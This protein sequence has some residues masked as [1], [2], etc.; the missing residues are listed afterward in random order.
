MKQPARETLDRYFD[1]ELSAEELEQFAVWLAESP[2]HAAEFASQARFEFLVKEAW[3][4]RQACAVDGAIIAVGG[5]D[6][7]LAGDLASTAA[8]RQQA[9][10][11]FSAFRVTIVMAVALL[12][13]AVAGPQIWSSWSRTPQATSHHAEFVSSAGEG[14][15]SLLPNAGETFATGPD[16]MGPE[17]LGGSDEVARVTGLKGV[18]WLAGHQRALGQRL[19]AGILRFQRGTVRIVFTGGVVASVVG[20][21]ELHLLAGDH[22]RLIAGTFAAY[23]P[24][25]AEGF[26]LD[27]PGAEITDLGTEFGASVDLDGNTDLSVF[28]GSVQ[29]VAKGDGNREIFTQGQGATISAAGVMRPQFLLA[30]F[31]EPRD[32]ISGYKIVWEPFGPGSATGPF[33]G[34][35]DAGWLG[36]WQIEASPA[37]EQATVATVTDSQPLHPGTERYLELLSA[38]G[39]GQQMVRLDARRPYGSVDSFSIEEPYTIECLVR[40]QSNPSVL[41][42]FEIAGFMGA[43]AEEN[44]KPCWQIVAGRDS[45]AGSIRWQRPPK[46]SGEEA[47]PGRALDTLMVGWWESWRI[48]VAVDPPQNRWRFMLASPTQSWASE[49]QTLSMTAGKSIGCHEIAFT[50]SG[51]TSHR[52][53]FAID[54]VKIRNRP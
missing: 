44:Q 38:M 37:T 42:R 47:A 50:A 8:T 14:F 24:P 33:P 27:T 17:Q 12:V 35:A 32:A 29:L 3:K 21:A 5:P 41:S 28:D 10:A 36:P 7:P 39:D 15:V 9:L 4:P 18:D 6:G 51:R 20:P 46:D 52:L 54:E 16:A 2:A 53:S 26:R 19:A 48:C 31:E 23:A 34:G 30:A 25:G 40:V 45:A 22:A 1:D 11:E 13:M 49:W 43:A